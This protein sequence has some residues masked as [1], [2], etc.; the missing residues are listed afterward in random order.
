MDL[1][2]LFFVNGTTL[3]GFPKGEEP[4]PHLYRNKNNGTFEDVTEAAGLR[5]QWGWGQGACAGD[6]DNDGNVDLF[7]TYYGHNHLFR[8][9]DGRFEDVTDSRWR[10]RTQRHGG[11][12]GVRF[13]TM[14]ATD[15]ST[16]S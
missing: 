2:D 4:R 15:V 11:A 10:R 13:S 7:V 1:E 3:E 14:T 6:Y 5:T 8:N 12:P 9:T 16:C